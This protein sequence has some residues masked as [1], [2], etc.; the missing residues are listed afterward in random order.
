MEEILLPS[1]YLSFAAEVCVYY[2]IDNNPHLLFK[3]R[4]M[5]PRNVLKIA[6]MLLT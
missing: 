5:K 3:S 4:S 1:F 6:V 2:L